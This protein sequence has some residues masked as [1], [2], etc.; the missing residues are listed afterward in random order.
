MDAFTGRQ[1]LSEIHAAAVVGL[2]PLGASSATIL[3]MHNE[4]KP[5]ATVTL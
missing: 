3:D 4:G 2:I 1:S 5:I